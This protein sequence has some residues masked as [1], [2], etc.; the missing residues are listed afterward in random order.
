MPFQLPP[1]PASV[2]ASVLAAGLMLTVAGCSHL[3][4]LGPDAR[5]AA[6]EPSAVTDR[7]AGHARPAPHASRRVP[8]RVHHALRA[9]QPRRATARSARR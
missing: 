7:P 9:G 5:R 8:G 6:A 1:R 3:T 4:P 2:L